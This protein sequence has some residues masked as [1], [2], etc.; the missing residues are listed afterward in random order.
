M[1]SSTNKHNGENYELAI[2]GKLPDNSTYRQDIPVEII[3]NSYNL[4]FALCSDGTI[5]V[6]A[7]FTR[8]LDVAKVKSDTTSFI[9]NVL[10]NTNEITFADFNT[11][12]TKSFYGSTVGENNLDIVVSGLSSIEESNPTNPVDLSAL[13]QGYTALNKFVFTSDYSIE[14]AAKLLAE[15]SLYYNGLPA[16]TKYNLKVTTS[17]KWISIEYLNE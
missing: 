8:K 15:K 2:F 10:K 1:V 13:K 17:S 16:T 11:E 7:P 14:D 3:E 9:T 6:I 12:G 4:A 5:I